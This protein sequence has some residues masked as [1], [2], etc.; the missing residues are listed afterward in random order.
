MILR[1]ALFALPLA[2]APLAFAGSAR[3]LPQPLAPEWNGGH[4]ESFDPLWNLL[5]EA[6][7]AT[8]PQKGVLR[9]SFPDSLRRLSGQALNLEGFIL[10]L[11]AG[12]QTRHFALTRRNSGCPFCP[13]NLPTEAVE[14]RTDR[15]VAVGPDLITIH[16]VLALRTDSDQGLFYEFGKAM[17]VAGG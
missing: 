16:G 15:P 13:P 1:R 8:D 5:D 2:L 12:R 14:V 6:H 7:V 17:V 11:E 10:P 4:P 9:A 3:A